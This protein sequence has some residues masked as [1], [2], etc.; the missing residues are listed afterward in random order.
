VTTHASQAESGT[1]MFTVALIGAD[2]A[3]KTTIGRRL[4]HSLPLPVKY[5]YMGINFDASN[6]MLPTTRVL[7]RLR[8]A[9]NGKR[10]AGG[11]PDPERADPPPIGLARRAVAG[12]G[13]GLGLA[14][15]L[16]EEWFRQGLAWYYQRR[17]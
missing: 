7:H 6:H 2:G 9:W 13:A 4:A 10:I 8:Q 5:V 16:S 15:R 1:T 3:G 17:G 11:P 14:I 12:A